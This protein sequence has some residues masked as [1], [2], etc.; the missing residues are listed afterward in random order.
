M[1]GVKTR[2]SLCVDWMSRWMSRH[3]K[4]ASDVT[5]RFWRRLIGPLARFG[6]KEDVKVN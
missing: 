6:G 5:L 3:R 1:K 2:G 4:R